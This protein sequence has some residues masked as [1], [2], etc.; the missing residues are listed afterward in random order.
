MIK[1]WSKQQPVIALSSGEAELYACNRGA[2]EALGVRSI[3]AELGIET[4]VTVEIDASATEGML[5]RRGL[6]KMR[7]VSVQEL[8][9]QEAVK[10][11]EYKVRKIASNKNSADMGTKPLSRWGIES[12]L[13]RMG[14]IC[15]SCSR[16]PQV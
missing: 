4:K 2:R 14:F 6:G 11:G 15:P 10:K 13:E 12:N 7:H 9:G 3:C 8:W 16:P 1:S 5:Q